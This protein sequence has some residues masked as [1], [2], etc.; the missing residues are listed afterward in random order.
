M[1]T[2]LARTAEGLLSLARRARDERRGEEAATLS[3]GA[4]VC[5]R[6]ACDAR[7]TLEA[8][9][10]LAHVRY[11]A[12]DMRAAEAAFREAA[13]TCEA[14][15][16]VMGTARLEA[17][18]AFAAIDRRDATTAVETLERVESRLAALADAPPKLEVIATVD[19]YRANLARQAG[20]LTQA[21]ASYERAIERARAAGATLWVA[22]FSMDR[23]AAELAGGFRDAALGWLG[24]AE[25]ELD[26]LPKSD[27]R[28]ALA[29]LV[30]HY[31][32]L[33][34]ISAGGAS[35]EVD[36]GP[37]SLEQVRVWLWDATRGG[38]RLPRLDAALARRLTALEETA[39]LEHARLGAR[40]LRVLASGSAASELRIARDGSSIVCG[41]SGVD[42]SRRASL[43]GALEALA[44]AHE[45]DSD[46]EV[47]LS[48]LIAA[49]WPGEK[50]QP[51]AA[52]N[53]AHVLLSTLRSVGL[54]DALLRG[55]TGY[56]LDPR[57]CR[58][59]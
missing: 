45:A 43:Q 19:G 40:I 27:A 14:R 31:L 29:P 35:I 59:A 25:R 36:G 33:A 2:E 54:G 51:Q 22:T 39:E 47:A 24:E 58:L 20:A 17:S 48:T 37:S 23:G 56:R 5:A 28:R 10:L 18:A 55:P 30:A 52:R 57:R 11:D 16:D 41:P 12:G 49:A 42:L 21:R 15:G 6:G 8:Q 38:T 34:R 1:A 46:A 53:R 13:G 50:I 26:A 4:L 32:A 3:S 9:T 44:R 7:L